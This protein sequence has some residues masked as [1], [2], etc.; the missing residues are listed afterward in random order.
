MLAEY[1]TDD[2][3]EE[4]V[5]VG[6]FAA[7]RTA[8]ESS[9]DAWAPAAISASAGETTTAMAAIRRMVTISVLA[10]NRGRLFIPEPPL[11]RPPWPCRQN[12]GWVRVGLAIS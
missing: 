5:D 4:S 10:I 8:L 2:V 11:G 12:A 6:F 7:A 3:D 9:V 1:V